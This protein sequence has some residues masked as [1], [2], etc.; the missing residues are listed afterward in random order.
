MAK[1]SIE[2][3]NSGNTLNS[4]SDKRIVQLQ[5]YLNGELEITLNKVF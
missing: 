3:W 5:T 1:D 4:K 2:I